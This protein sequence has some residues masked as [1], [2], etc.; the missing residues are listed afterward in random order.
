MVV[1]VDMFMGTEFCINLNVESVVSPISYP[2]YLQIMFPIFNSQRRN[3]FLEKF[4]ERDGEEKKR[5]GWL[6]PSSVFLVFSFSLW[7]KW[8]KRRGSQELGHKRMVIR[9]C[10]NEQ[11]ATCFPHAKSFHFYPQY[12]NLKLISNT[13]MQILN[14]GSNFFWKYH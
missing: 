1:V 7:G 12:K 6:I 13:I 3:F 5:R 2:P 10:C 9:C 11:H 14:I 4:E 8:R